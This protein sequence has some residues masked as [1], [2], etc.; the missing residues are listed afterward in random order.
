MIKNRPHYWS[1]SKF[2]DWIRGEKKPYALELGKWSEW[3]K[4]QKQIR[5]WR[6]WLSDTVLPKIQNIVCLPLDI[7]RTIKVYVRNRFFDKL[8]YLDTGL[9]RGKYYDLDYRI[10]HGLFNELVDFVELELAHLSKWDKDKKYKFVKGRCQEAQDDYFKWANHLK[11]QGRLTEQAKASRKIKELYEWWKYIRPQRVDPY[12]SSS[13]SYDIDE[14]LDGKKIKQKQKLA[15]KAYDLE[16]KYDNED[17]EM[18][19]ELIK[20]RNHLWT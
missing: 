4:E 12:S 19:I 1:C 5:P 11:H 10:L 6:F 13:F 9:K 14:I 17:T 18:L 15:K 2:A 20:V 7:Y 3:K 8:H 16:A